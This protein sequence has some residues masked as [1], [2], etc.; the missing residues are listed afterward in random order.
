MSIELKAYDSSWPEQYERA[1]EGIKR[2]LGA[3]V[4]EIEHVR[5]TS[6]PGMS[7]EPIIDIAAKV[8]SFDCVGEECV[9]R[10][11]ISA[12]FTCRTS[13]SRQGAFFGRDLPVQ[14]ATIFTFSKREAVNMRKW[15][16]SGISYE[17]R[18]LPQKSIWN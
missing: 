3:A 6:I 1:K 7:A 18:R 10:L 16:C 8:P 5:S 15:F 11:P 17:V 14:E 13:G 12:T 9:Q 2:V 4:F